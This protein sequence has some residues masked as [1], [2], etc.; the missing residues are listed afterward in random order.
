MMRKIS[1]HYD[2]VV[3]SSVFHAMD[4]GSAF[5]RKQELMQIYFYDIYI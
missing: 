2:D 3:A 4:V 1:I 5:E